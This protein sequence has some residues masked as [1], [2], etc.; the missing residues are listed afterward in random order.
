MELAGAAPDSLQLHESELVADGLC[1]ICLVCM[2]CG[3][4][5]ACAVDQRQ[6]PCTSLLHRYCRDHAQG[7]SRYP[8]WQGLMDNRRLRRD[9]QNT[10]VG[11]VP[12]PSG[13]LGG[14]PRHAQVAC[15]A[16][17]TIALKMSAALR[18]LAS[19]TWGSGSPSCDIPMGDATRWTLAAPS[20]AQMTVR[21]WGLLRDHLRQ[22]SAGSPGSVKSGFQGDVLGFINAAVGLSP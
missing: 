18:S 2:E 3:N 13:E 8:P 19:T 12:S 16:P 20:A 17:L 9:G 15:D 1:G 14:L 22:F 5:L 4:Q 21:R 6:I 10:S 11:A 7:R